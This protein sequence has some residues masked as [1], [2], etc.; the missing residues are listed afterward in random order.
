MSWTDIEP[1]IGT[2]YKTIVAQETCQ[3]FNHVATTSSGSLHNQE[4]IFMNTSQAINRAQRCEESD[5]MQSKLDDESVGD[6]TNS[7]TWT[8]ML[9]SVEGDSRMNGR[10]SRKLLI[11]KGYS[12]IQ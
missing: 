6:M 4:H 8:S 7:A 11:R 12:Y 3:N 1:D 5:V 2:S 10:M 9:D